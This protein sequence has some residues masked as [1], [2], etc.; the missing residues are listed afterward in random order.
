MVGASA[1]VAPIYPRFRNLLSTIS[2]KCANR[3]DADLV[4]LMMRMRTRVSE[5]T[6]D[7]WVEV[8][9]SKRRTNLLGSCTRDS[10]R[11]VAELAISSTLRLAPVLLGACSRLKKRDGEI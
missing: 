10:A 3:R 2:R 5:R 8:P 9:H 4:L 7:S 11:V 1:R 6:I